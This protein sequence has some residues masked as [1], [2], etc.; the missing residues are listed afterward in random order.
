MPPKPTVKAN[1]LRDL[2]IRYAAAEAEPLRH[3]VIITIVSA[4]L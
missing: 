3:A 2:R 1:I 4:N